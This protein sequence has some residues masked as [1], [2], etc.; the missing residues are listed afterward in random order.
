[1][2]T[3]T[4]KEQR[5]RLKKIMIMSLTGSGCKLDY[6]KNAMDALFK[7]IEKQD[8]QASKDLKKEFK[9]YLGYDD[10]VDYIINKIFGRWEE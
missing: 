6:A 10:D 5:E 1:M 9:D 3:K 4:L 7:E 2:E 8:K